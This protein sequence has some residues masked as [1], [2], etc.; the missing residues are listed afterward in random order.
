MRI[1]IICNFLLISYVSFAQTVFEKEIGKEYQLVRGFENTFEM[2]VNKCSDTLLNKIV[3]QHIVDQQRILKNIGYPSIVDSDLTCLTLI[4]SSLLRNIYETLL[5]RE[6]LQNKLC[7]VNGT[8]YQRKTCLIYL[9]V[10]TRKAFG[11]YT[12]KMSKVQYSIE[13]PTGQVIVR[14]YVDLYR[15][16]SGYIMLKSDDAFRIYPLKSP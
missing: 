10:F 3:N 14:N 6:S 5:S 4:D 11:K 9:V 2:Y 7:F 15:Y 16:A 12:K 8:L 13:H 1:L